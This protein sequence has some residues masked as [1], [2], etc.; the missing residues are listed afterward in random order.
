M[1]IKITFAI[2]CVS[3]IMALIIAHE[4][5]DAKAANAAKLANAIAEA[6]AAEHSNAA[7]HHI[8]RAIL[9]QEVQRLMPTLPATALD[10]YKAPAIMRQA[11]VA[12][13]HSS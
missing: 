12:R 4:Y 7:N 1:I 11:S 13:R 2:Q 10:D 9:R 5:H 8:Q 6:N 3:I